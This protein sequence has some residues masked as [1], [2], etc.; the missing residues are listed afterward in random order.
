MNLTLL[1][2]CNHISTLL[3]EKQ[4][5]LWRSNNRENA[6]R[7]DMTGK[8]WTSPIPIIVRDLI[9]VCNATTSSYSSALYWLSWID[10]SQELKV[11]NDNRSRPYIP[12]WLYNFKYQCLWYT[13]ISR[14]KYAFNL[15]RLFFV[16]CVIYL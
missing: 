11:L 9:S 8:C 1:F 10:N 7:K 3:P 15:N 16:H 14:L 12:W 6:C 4:F 2:I 5:W 13:A